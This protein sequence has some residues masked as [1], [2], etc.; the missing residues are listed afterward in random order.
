MVS[1]KAVDL[2]VAV[3][4]NGG[5]GKDGGIPWRLKGDLSFF[6]QLTTRTSKLNAVLMG[7]K[8]WESI[9]KSLRPLKGRLNVVLTRN[10]QFS[11]DGA[12]VYGSLDDALADL[13]G[14]EEIGRVFVIGGSR[15][16][17]EAL[18]VAERVY[19]TKVAGAFDCDAFFPELDRAKFAQ[20]TREEAELQLE[21][22]KPL[23]R[24]ESGVRFEFTVYRR[25][26][27]ISQ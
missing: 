16:Y 9:P 17:E 11:A 4:E 26:G 3:C 6:R 25:L 23:E 27:C 20:L 19:V 21:W 1:K 13:F 7:R 10:A 22:A 15:V 24:E 5:I 18:A 2:V 12:V 14:R 8:T